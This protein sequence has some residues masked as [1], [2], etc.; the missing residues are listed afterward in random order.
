VLRLG[1]AS[2]ELR[3][4]LDEDVVL[5]ALYGALYHRLT[6]PYAPLSDGYVEALVDSVFGG[7]QKRR[8]RQTRK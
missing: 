3:P 4:G 8:G 5:D 6:I 2:G 7:L 1:V